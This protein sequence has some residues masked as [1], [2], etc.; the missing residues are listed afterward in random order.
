MEREVLVD[1]AGRT[2]SDYKRS[3]RCA[4]LARTIRTPLLDPWR[5]H[6]NSASALLARHPPKLALVEQMVASV[7]QSVATGCPDV[8]VARNTQPLTKIRVAKW[9]RKAT[10]RS[11]RCKM[12]KP[13]L[14]ECDGWKSRLKPE[15]RIRSRAGPNWQQRINFSV[16]SLRTFSAHPGLTFHPC[17]AAQKHV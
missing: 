9:W 5:S 14:E 1:L 17:V 10:A 15:G 7:E 12:A 6:V 4:S 3:T 2:R 16:P 11:G 8:G 13:W